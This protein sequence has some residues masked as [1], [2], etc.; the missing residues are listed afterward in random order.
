MQDQCTP[1]IEMLRRL[2]RLVNREVFAVCE[3]RNSC[4]LTSATLRDVLEQLGI[5]ATLM[6][7]ETL[8][9][10]SKGLVILG[11]DGD[12]RRLPAAQPG[13]WRGH[14]VVIAAQRFLMDATLDQ[15]D[16]LTPF[17]G[18]IT[19]DWLHAEK[20]LWWVNGMRVDR[21]S[22]DETKAAV[23][24]HSF[25]GRGG[26]RSAPDFRPTRRRALVGAIL[27]AWEE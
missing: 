7:V 26:W 17:V 9:F 14:V 13:V 21:L 15:I 23:R 16:G 19:E 2:C 20:T 5:E 24:Y 22:S 4:I 1:D 11:S 8:G 12:G 10:G 27:S 18:E 25:P 3:V 6:R